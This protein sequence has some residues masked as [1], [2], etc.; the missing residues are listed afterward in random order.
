MSAPPRL[1]PPPRNAPPAPEPEAAPFADALA[2]ILAAVQ[3]LV[4]TLALPVLLAL[5]AFLVATGASTTDPGGAAS[6]GGDAG[7][8]GPVALAAGL[9]LLGHGVPFATAEVTFTLVPLGATALVVF[10]CYVAGKRPLRPSVGSWV[11]GAAAYGTGTTAVAAFAGTAPGWSLAWAP[12]CGVVVGG[13]GLGL[14]ILARPDRPELAWLGA[15]AERF[16]PAV[17]RLGARA[18]LVAAALVTGAAALLVTAWAVAG[19]ATSSDIVTALAPGWAGG[20]VLAVAQLALLPDVVAWAAAWLAGPGF[21]VGEGTRFAVFGTESGPLPA[22]PLLGALPGP[23]WSNAV[24]AWSPAVVVAC[25]VVAGIFAWQRLEPTLVRWADVGWVLGGLT[26]AVGALTLVVQWAASGA[27][28]P[29]RL[30]T[31]GADPLITA[32]LVAAE[33]GGGAAVAMVGAR[34]DLARR[35]DDLSAWLADRRTR[36]AEVVAPSDEATISAEGSGRDG[37]FVLAEPGDPGQAPA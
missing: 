28:G 23:D 1:R 12:L 15:R 37:A 17:L 3:A 19:R 27:G 16:A 26:G 2:G 31:V 30:A 18:G 7:W 11:A 22:L 14:G 29:G 20:I 32:G 33:V 6:A 21:A 25:G 13:L 35:R 8:R 5:T 34:L 36:S 9:W 24:S 4:L 10:A